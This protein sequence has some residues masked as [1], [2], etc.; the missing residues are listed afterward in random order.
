MITAAVIAAAAVRLGAKH[1][2]MLMGGTNMHVIHHFADAGAALH[3]L[4]HEN[5]VVGA[6]D[7]YA[8]ATGDV[9]WS[10]VIQ[11]P[12]LTNAMTALR[13]AVKARSPQ[14]LLLP[15]T[16]AVP[17]RQNPFEAGVQGL[18]ADGILADIG[19]PVVRVSADTAAHDTVSAY[20]TAKRTRSPVALVIP[21]GVETAASA[22]DV[23]N[24]TRLVDVTTAP[25]VPSDAA[26]DAAEHA[27]RDA[28]QV[29]ILAGRGAAHPEATAL[30]ARL[31]ELTGAYLA[32]SVKAIGI[33]NDSPANLGIF[34][35][36][37]HAA[38][39]QAID[40]ANCVLAFGASLNHL[41]TRSSTYLTG[42]VVVQVDADEL[43]LNK[44]DRVAVPVHGD[45]IVVARTLVSRLEACP[46][47]PA[48]SLPTAPAAEPWDD[49]SATDQL[50]PRAVASTLD[51]LLP[52][53]RTVVV[54]SGHFTSWPITHM[55]HRGPDT[56][57]W[58]ADFGAVGSGIGPSLGA[59]VGRPDR[60]TVLVVGDCGFYMAMGDLEVAVRERIPLVV[61]CF[62]DGAA[63]SEL[64]LAEYA[65]LSPDEAI[66]GVADLAKAA[67]GL[68]ASGV[69]VES[70][71]DLGHALS[72]WDRTGPLF[73][74]FHITRAVHAPRY[75]EY[76]HRTT[77]G[78][79]R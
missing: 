19:V 28:K 27:L 2:F 37:T 22:D 38:G 6:A 51:R 46:L 78:A 25:V 7:G 18:A 57:L 16:S 1:L 64:L 62:N 10:S 61:A 39:K 34:G 11:G 58:T 40:E 42:K 70:L 75:K 3:H 47:E 48:R 52:A 53:E 74:D 79:E 65:D 76:D 50:D 55:R 72:A 60:T 4:R 49:V 31:A 17:P 5:A 26:I 20:L 67:I 43:A 44:H 30:L 13:T 36:F 71:D 41:Q 8:R 35:G 12:G 66:F 33:F 77:D 29:V 69:V 59:A 21:H 14:V 32:T 73:L 63:G 45:T 24:A 9:G 15:D 56:M 54:D 23:E 68:G